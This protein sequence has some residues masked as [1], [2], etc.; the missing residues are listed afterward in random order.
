MRST[1]VLD[2]LDTLLTLPMSTFSQKKKTRLPPKSKKASAVAPNLAQVQ[3]A[4]DLFAN[5]KICKSRFLRIT[6]MNRTGELTVFLRRPQMSTTGR[7]KKTWSTLRTKFANTE[8]SF[9]KES[10]QTLGLVS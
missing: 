9:D 2:D 1:P 4:T 7:S 3:P 10:S 6:I 5:L 8:L